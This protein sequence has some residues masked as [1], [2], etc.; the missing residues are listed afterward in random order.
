MFGVDRAFEFFL[1]SAWWLASPA[2]KHS[3]KR[4]R[5]EEDGKLKSPVGVDT[6]V[7]ESAFLWYA[8]LCQRLLICLKNIRESF[9]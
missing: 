2:Q 3:C 8:S 4:R 1:F 7:A 5:R 6:N 9:Q